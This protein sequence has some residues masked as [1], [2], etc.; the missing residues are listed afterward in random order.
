MK[1]YSLRPSKQMLWQFTEFISQRRCPSFYDL[2]C[3][4]SFFWSKNSLSILAPP[5][6]PARF[7][8]RS[9]EMRDLVLP[10]LLRLHSLRRQCLALC[11][12]HSACKCAPFTW[13]LHGSGVGSV[14]VSCSS[15]RMHQRFSRKCCLHYQGLHHTCIPTFFFTKRKMSS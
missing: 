6:P 2:F 9:F 10:A 4:Y 13:K 8:V 3:N 14:A 11:D 15:A 5:H 7:G 12:S 1:F